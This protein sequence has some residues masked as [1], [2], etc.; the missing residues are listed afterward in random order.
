MK[1]II[2]IGLMV[3]VSTA[4]LAHQT[5]SAQRLDNAL[6]SITSKLNRIESKLRSITGQIEE[7]DKTTET[8]QKDIR[9]QLADRQ[10]AVKSIDKDI[11]RL[12]KAV[13]RLASQTP[14]SRRKGSANKNK[15][16]NL[17]KKSPD[18]LYGYALD[19]LKTKRKFNEAQRAFELFVRQYPD[20]SKAGQ[21]LYWLGESLYVRGNFRDA[22]KSYLRCHTFYPSSSKAADC[23]LRLGT[24]LA[25]LHEWEEA[26]SSFDKLRSDFPT[27]APHILQKLSREYERIQCSS[28]NPQG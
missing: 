22:A 13:K 9:N 16:E 27:A 19:Q 18:E 15:R 6:S 8:N 28:D 4:S 10:E 25:S 24:A 17:S 26:C 23:W 20:N 14:L 1:K 11:V 2:A 5:K 7:L 3:M 12:K 21:A